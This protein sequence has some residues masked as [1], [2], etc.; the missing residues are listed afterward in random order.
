MNGANTTRIRDG[1]KPRS[2]LLTSNPLPPN[3]LTPAR[4]ESYFLSVIDALMAFDSAMLPTFGGAN[5]LQNFVQAGHDYAL[6]RLVPGSAALGTQIQSPGIN[7]GGRE[8]RA[9]A[10]PGRRPRPMALHRS[11]S[12]LNKEARR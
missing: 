12:P 4:Q 7:P 5:N 1:G 8:P 11:H 9:L 10:A 2:C 3:P 6:F